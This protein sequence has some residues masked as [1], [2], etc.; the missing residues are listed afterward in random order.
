MIF[1]GTLSVYLICFNSVLLLVTFSSVFFG[2]YASFAGN[3]LIGS[4]LVYRF[5]RAATKDQTIHN[6]PQQLTTP[7]QRKNN[8]YSLVNP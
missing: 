6:S 1:N 3:G 8:G 5:T 7:K 4:V 2:V